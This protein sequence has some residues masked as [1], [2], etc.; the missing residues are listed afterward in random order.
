MKYFQQHNISVKHNWPDAQHD[1]LIFRRRSLIP[2]FINFPRTWYIP[3]RKGHFGH[4]LGKNFKLW[5]KLSKL[6]RFS[7]I[8]W[9][10]TILFLYNSAHHLANCLKVII[11]LLNVIWLR[12]KRSVF[13][14]TFLIWENEKFNWKSLMM[15]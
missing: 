5:I 3:L 4:V 10:H 8:Q 14:Q 2:L 9:I 12:L 1:I 11:F 6:L 7:I 15:Y 13:I